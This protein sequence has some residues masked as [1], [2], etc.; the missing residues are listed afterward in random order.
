MS[1]EPLHIDEESQ[2][3][4]RNIRIQQSSTGFARMK[5]MQLT[6]KKDHDAAL[7]EFDDFYTRRMDHFHAVSKEENES[8]AEYIEEG[9]A[10][11]ADIFLRL[12]PDALP[13]L[14]PGDMAVTK[15]NLEAW[16][17]E[18]A[19]GVAEH[20][21]ALRDVVAV[22]IQDFEQSGQSL[23]NRL[24]DIAHML[25][26]PIE[27]DIVAPIVHKAK[28]ALKEALDGLEE[29]EQ[30]LK[31]E[32]EAVEKEYREKYDTIYHCWM[33]ARHRQLVD[34]FADQCRCREQLWPPPLTFRYSAMASKT[35]DI[36]EK[37]NEILRN[38]ESVLRE[39]T[40]FIPQNDVIE[41]V[42]ER[43][44]LL[45]KEVQL[46]RADI[47]T[48][49]TPGVEATEVGK[50]AR[51]R[52][53][54][55]SRITEVGFITEDEKVVEE[56]RT[57][58]DP[59]FNEWR[60][61]MEQIR[62]HVFRTAETDL[63]HAEGATDLLEAILRDVD[64]ECHA[65]VCELDDIEH[66]FQEAVTTAGIQHRKN[67]GALKAQLEL[68]EAEFAS[69]KDEDDVDGLEGRGRALLDD[70]EKLHRD[71]Y[72]E[73]TDLGRRFLPDI[74]RCMA[75]GA[76]RIIRPTRVAVV[77]SLPFHV[78]RSKPASDEGEEDGDKPFE[79]MTDE[80]LRMSDPVDRVQGGAVNLMLYRTVEDLFAQFTASPPNIEW[81]TDPKLT[82]ADQPEGDSAVDGA[83]GDGGNAVEREENEDATRARMG[84]TAEAYAARLDDFD[85]DVAESVASNPEDILI[86]EPMTNQPLHIRLHVLKLELV[87]LM[88]GLLGCLASSLET[89]YEDRKQQA[90]AMVSHVNASLD[91]E[92]VHRLRTLVPERVRL[93]QAIP[94]ASRGYLAR[95][96]A[97]VSRA[98]AQTARITA[99]MAT[100]FRLNT[101]DTRGRQ[102]VEELEDLTLLRL[103]ESDVKSRAGTDLPVII[104]AYVKAFKTAKRQCKKA[105]TAPE[106]GAAV[107]NL[108][109]HIAGPMTK[110]LAELRARIVAGA[111]VRVKT[112]QTHHKQLKTTLAEFTVES[113]PLGLN[114]GCDRI[115]ER[116]L[117]QQLDVDISTTAW[118]AEVLR[119]AHGSA[120]ALEERFERRTAVLTARDN[121]ERHRQRA[122]R[123]ASALI[124]GTTD[125]AQEMAAKVADV[126]APSTP[127][128][129]VR[130]VE[131][132]IAALGAV[133]QAGVRAGMWT[134]TVTDN[135][136]AQ[137]LADA[138]ADAL[139]QPH[140]KLASLVPTVGGSLKDDVAG[141]L[142]QFNDRVHDQ[143]GGVTGA[144]S[145]K[146]GIDAW[147]A[148]LNTSVDECIKV[149]AEQVQEA[150]DPVLT[151]VQQAVGAIVDAVVAHATE[152]YTEQVERR[153]AE[154]SELVNDRREARNIARG[155]LRPSLR[156]RSGQAMLKKVDEAER[157]SQTDF[158]AKVTQLWIDVVTEFVV[159]TTTGLG[160]LGAVLQR[161]AALYS[162]IPVEEGHN[163]ALAPM[164]LPETV[165]QSVEEAAAVPSWLPDQDPVEFKPE[166]PEL[167][168]YDAIVPFSENALRSFASNTVSGVRG[169]T[170]QLASMFEWND[171]WAK[172]WPMLV[173]QLELPEETIAQ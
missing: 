5:Q 110:A 20:V 36:V 150:Q 16:I 27:R 137:D 29:V 93:S 167:S 31:V 130:W 65:M 25:R 68:V 3:L 81:E 132:A 173:A 158:T 140:V 10:A 134:G 38:F 24:D 6:R 165:V 145:I 112:I 142:A 108:N 105:K 87:P 7:V 45:K 161:V 164:T 48:A 159:A 135:A 37:R 166:L 56:V 11:V 59:P 119:I 55:V 122:D 78:P 121:L 23:A 136:V 52:E 49:E 54:L 149:T 76:A 113:D 144:D 1:E 131:R 88:M 73:I 163:L 21:A 22:S 28:A 61:H 34:T 39:S 117:M 4:S 84:V 69:L 160:H 50:M 90:R 138:V 103:L 26:E 156:I 57:M 153:S 83:E 72:D 17:E 154:L 44:A 162:Q 92:L 151:S 102:T 85:E 43:H 58:V 8:F 91:T 64:R 115:E 139:E 62:D 107:R 104:A 155:S 169:I 109:R 147:I 89:E 148:S 9:K 168:L 172:D 42:R 116:A 114:S 80:E 94:A 18:R 99:E 127:A 171:D 53:T 32:Q 74:E 126:A 123:A 67:E 133:R 129:C 100:D 96:R 13:F 170:E 143:L 79:E 46:C 60:R 12:Q 157:A 141:R 71:F 146:A 40:S 35:K 2:D 118:V 51:E 125:D 19:M 120:K 63:A 97:H 128:E 152:N 33:E 124:R 47:G 66:A 106:A 14:S 70:L 15:T 77:E 86:F 101:R 30:T 75:Q 111:T 41:E 98:L 82:D 95:R